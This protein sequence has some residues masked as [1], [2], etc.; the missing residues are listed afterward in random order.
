M[1]ILFKKSGIR[2]N[3]PKGLAQKQSGFLNFE[4]IFFFF[5]AFFQCKKSPLLGGSFFRYGENSSI[6]FKHLSIK[7]F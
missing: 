4:K 1:T 6:N 3:F 2:H 5:F 7:W